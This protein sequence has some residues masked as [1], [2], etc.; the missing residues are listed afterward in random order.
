MV[1]LKGNKGDGVAA[2]AGSTRATDDLGLSRAEAI[3]PERRVDLEVEVIRSVAGVA[4]LE[5]E[6][7][8]LRTT[9]RNTVPFLLYEWQL[10]WVKHFLRQEPGITDEP[11]FH[12][13]RDSSGRCVAI[14]PFIRTQRRLG[15]LNFR[16]VSLL[17]G[18]P[19]ITEIRAYLVAPGFEAAV[20]QALESS[21]ERAR[22][23]DCIHWLGG[24]DRFSGAVGLLRKLDWHA[25]PPGYVLDLPPT[26]E[27]FRAGLK[28]NIRESLRH[29]YNS[30]KRGGHG[31]EFTVATAPGAVREALER[32]YVLHAMRAAMPGRVHHPDHF[33]PAQIRGFLTDVCAALS[34]RDAVCVFEL[35]IAGRVVASRLGFR[36]GDSLY[37]YYSGF[38]PAWSKYSVMTTTMAESLKYAI[39]LGLTTVNL[40]P[41]NDVSK[42][43]WGPREVPYLSAFEANGRLGSRLVSRAYIKAQSG[44]GLQGWLL[45]RLL[46]GR[47]HWL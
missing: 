23:W 10:T 32:L 2:E 19:A 28:R 36:V 33:A 27:E 29:C 1:H 16:S 43:R 18:D 31:F 34:A 7:V 11:M 42:T 14:I 44:E 4:Q 9:T 38:D 45:Q 21:L 47:R 39:R 30:L 17:G 8:H 40:S 6:F 22:D 41:G 13:V 5:A 3:V 37:L 24:C 35:R 46:P 12:V 26:W 20:A 25:M 15:R